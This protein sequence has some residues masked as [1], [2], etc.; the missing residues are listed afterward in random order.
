MSERSTINSVDEMLSL[1]KEKIYAQ[2]GSIMAYIANIPQQV[3]SNDVIGSCIQDWL[4][5]WFEDN[6]VNLTA[7]NKTQC[8]PD[9]VAHFDDKDIPMDI[10]V[11]NYGNAAPA[12]DIANFDSFYD[13]VTKNIDKLIAKY[14]VIG[15]KTNAHGFSIEYLD[16]KNIWEMIGPST[17]YPISIQVK[18]NKPYA[19]RPVAFH[20]DNGKAFNDLSKLLDAVAET[21]RIFPS[22]NNSQLSPSTWI[23]TV[24]RELV[25]KGINV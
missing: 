18:R 15:Y 4:P 21:R 3:F 17:K 13:E 20:K 22:Q 10:K 2:Q 23:K 5:A 19:I 16:I 11:W 12:F 8:F 9:F 25:E 24:K 14:I 1:M 7:N 6:N